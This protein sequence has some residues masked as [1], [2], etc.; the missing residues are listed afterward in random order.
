MLFRR[1]ILKTAAPELVE[2]KTDAIGLQPQAM[3]LILSIAKPG[4]AAEALP[5]RVNPAVFAATEPAA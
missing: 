5:E 3:A 4:A 1:H 2:R